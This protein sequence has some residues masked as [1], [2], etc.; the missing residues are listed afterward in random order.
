ME[1]GRPCQR[2]NGDLSISMLVG[3]MIF[4]DA[5]GSL[6]GRSVIG[7]KHGIE[8]VPEGVIDEPLR[9]GDTLLTVGPW[10][11]I[12]QL[13]DERRDLVLLDLPAESDEAV[14]ARHRAPL[15]V[16]VLALVVVLTVWGIVPNVQA[17][18]SGCL[19]G[20]FSTALICRGLIGRSVGKACLIVG[21]LPF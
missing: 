14:P 16:G 19:C 2:E 15:A 7:M 17:A 8:P 21:M 5:E 13:T 12:H 9:A 4:S 11:A 20:V 18:L 3:V 6:F 1:T 10:R